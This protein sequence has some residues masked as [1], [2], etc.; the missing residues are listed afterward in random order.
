MEQWLSEMEQNLLSWLSSW[1]SENQLSW[2]DEYL[3]P[4]EIIVVIIIGTISLLILMNIDSRKLE[5]RI[6]SLKESNPQVQF[7][8]LPDENIISKFMDPAGIMEFHF[9]NEIFEWFNGD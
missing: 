4:I 7:H 1:L 5:K 9:D 8:P 2:I 3:I 6:E